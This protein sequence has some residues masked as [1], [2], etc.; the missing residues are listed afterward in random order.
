MQNKTYW[1]MGGSGSGKTAASEIFKELGFKV[2]DAD[3]V[4]RQIMEKGQGAYNEAVRAFGTEILLPDGTINRKKLGEAVFADSEKLGI[5]GK[6]THKYIKRE[7]CRIVSESDSDVLID[8]AL[9]PKEFCECDKVI[10]VTAPREQRIARI[11]ARDGISLE[12]AENRLNSQL[13]DDEYDAI[14]DVSFQNDGSLDDLKQKIKKWC[15]D[16]KII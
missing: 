14:A 11:M 7:L 9:P 16:E 4:A 1:L 10:F 6:I 2:V 5:L 13:T 3:K 15:V 12:S 8:A